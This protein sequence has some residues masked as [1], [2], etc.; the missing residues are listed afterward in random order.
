MKVWFIREI[1]TGNYIPEAH[2]RRGRGGSHMEPSP[3]RG[4]ARIFRSRL[5]AARFLGAWLKGKYVADRGHTT[6]HPG[7]DW[8]ADYYEDISIVPVYT[9]HR[10]DME[11]IE[12]EIDL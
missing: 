6:G 5:S 12:K 2:G 8:E 4:E 9:R 3:N 7:N 11:I 1:S 10:E